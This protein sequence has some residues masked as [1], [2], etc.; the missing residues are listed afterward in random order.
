MARPLRIQ[1]PGA[2]YHV[3]N[4][5]TS[6]LPTFF[7]NDHKQMFLGVL[8]DAVNTWDLRVHAFCLMTNHY[9]LLLETPLGNLSRAMRHIDGVYTQKIN[10]LTGR[11]GSLFRGRYKSLLVQK[12]TYFLALVRYIHMN[13]VKA[14]IYSHAGED[15]YCSHM[16]Y[17][18]PALRPAWLNVGDILNR[19]GGDNELARQRLD[20]FV[21]ADVGDKLN[22]LLEGKVWPA[23]IGGKKFIETIRDT[24]S[25]EQKPHPEK[26]QEKEL[27]RIVAPEEILEEIEAI[28]KLPEG[29]LWTMRGKHHNEPRLAAI[30]LLRKVC[31]L[32]YR[33][34]GER[35]GGVG[36][37]TI[38]SFLKKKPL[39]S[40]NYEALQKRFGMNQRLKTQT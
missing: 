13:G 29:R 2:L 35:M 16:F 31:L 10:K 26:P 30:H 36:A 7:S 9:H 12:E 3:M 6:R 28:Y 32:S 5:G 17:M 25:P 19:F 8:S 20:A 18:N 40:R 14:N 38:A 39:H 23:V 1:Y 15:L 21:H 22:R 27:R 37:G 4:R 34:I 33:Q 11:D 24:Y